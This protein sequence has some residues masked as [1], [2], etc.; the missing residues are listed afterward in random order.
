MTLEFEPAGKWFEQYTYLRH[1][2]DIS[3]DYLSDSESSADEEEEFV[4]TPE[5]LKF[6]QTLDPK[7]WKVNNN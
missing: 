5:Y 4:E 3:L 2:G 1:E 7:D 6:L